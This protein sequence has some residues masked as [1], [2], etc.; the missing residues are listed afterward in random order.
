MRTGLD[1]KQANSDN[2]NNT[3]TCTSSWTITLYSEQNSYYL[4][5]F[6]EKD[7]KIPVVMFLKLISAGVFCCNHRNIK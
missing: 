2:T 3:H 1:Y 5:K 4:H 7:M 6:V